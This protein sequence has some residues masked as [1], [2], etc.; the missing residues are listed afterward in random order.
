[1][2]LTI[3]VVFVVILLALVG[4]VISVSNTF[5]RA[6]VKIEEADSGIDVALTKRYDVLTKMWDAVK[7]YTKYER[8]TV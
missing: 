7:G 5:N 8:E 3:I 4:Y 1:M 2:L 6:I